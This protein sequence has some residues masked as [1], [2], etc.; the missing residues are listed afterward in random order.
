VSARLS[1]KARQ[2]IFGTAAA[3]VFLAAHSTAQAF[4]EM[5]WNYVTTRGA[6]AQSDIPV[7]ERLYLAGPEWET[8]LS[9]DEPNLALGRDKLRLVRWHEGITFAEVLKGMPVGGNGRN[10]LI[11]VWRSS[12]PPVFYYVAP[13]PDA[14]PAFKLRPHDVIEIRTTTKPPGPQRPSPV[15]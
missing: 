11:G 1:S 3:L 13:K 2:F 12:W 9:P 7:A 14:F 6:A 10:I 8:Y 15:V 5:E 4:P